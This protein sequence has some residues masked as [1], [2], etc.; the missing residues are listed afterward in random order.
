MVAHDIL[1]LGVF[2]DSMVKAGNY[3]LDAQYGSG[4][5]RLY[6]QTALNLWH[7]SA[8]T[9]DNTYRDWV[10]TI[11][12]DRLNNGTYGPNQ[13]LDI[14]AFIANIRT[15]A[16]VAN[17]KAWEIS[18]QVLAAERYC[19]QAIADKFEQGTLEAL[20]ALDNTD[21]GKFYDVLGLAGGV[22]GLARVNRLDFPEIIA[23]NHISVNGE[24][25]LAGLADE[26]V[27][28]QNSNGSFYWL[29]GDALGTPTPDQ[30]D[31]QTTAYAVLALIKAQERLPSKNYH[32]AI[33]LG[34]AWLL[35]M[36]E[37][38]GGF[39]GYPG[40]TDYN[41]EVEAEAIQAL[42]AEGVYDRI[43]QGQMECYVN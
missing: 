6:S 36:Q 31:T 3:N 33:E 34:K 24:T 28:L 27:A 8:L 42:G 12:Y 25:T 10:E 19:E 40:D 20:A 11:F 32:S 7:L 22:F 16:S 1:G 15:G 41:A 5:P 26:L 17:L 4:N 23:P 18:S 39:M 43:F 29:S 30:Q 35:T 2:M 14:D 37:A 38:D 21:P 13:D 9:G